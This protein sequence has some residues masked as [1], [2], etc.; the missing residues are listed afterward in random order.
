MTLLGGAP[1]VCRPDSA[2]WIAL[3]HR[4]GIRRIVK[5]ESNGLW[6]HSTLLARAWVIMICLQFQ[7]ISCLLIQCQSVMAFTPESPYRGSNLKAVFTRVC[8]EKL[9]HKVLGIVTSSGNDIHGCCGRFGHPSSNPGCMLPQQLAVYP[10]LN[11]V[12]G[13]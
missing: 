8:E 12:S 13:R 5:R 10:Q 1:K 11:C 9:G 7:N 3:L 4:M 2:V 6:W